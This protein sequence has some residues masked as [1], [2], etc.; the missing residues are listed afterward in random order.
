MTEE[1]VR[2]RVMGIKRYGEEWG[3]GCRSRKNLR[4]CGVCFN[5]SYPIIQKFVITSKCSCF[6]SS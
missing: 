2:R 6:N 1:E 5:G 4:H 3:G